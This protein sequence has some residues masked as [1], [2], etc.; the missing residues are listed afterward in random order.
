MRRLTVAGLPAMLAM[1]LTL[2]APACKRAKH[3]ESAPELLSVVRVDDP[4]A[5]AQLVGG[6]YS[7][8]GNTWRWTA[9]KFSVN[10]RPPSRGAQEGAR[11][12]LRLNIP[13]VVFR[14][15]GAVTLSATAGGSS[16]A[17]QKYTEAGDYVYARDV[18]AGALSG[19][20]VSIQFAT[21]KAIPAGKLEKRELG[22][23][24]SS[25]GLV[26]KP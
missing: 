20:S 25:I 26:S 3:T 15:M 17:P 23:I 5:E 24:V 4:R 1:G 6:F 8:E 22:L 19:D 14:Q 10:L 18:P 16:L 11:L 7:L 21:D 13:D 2:A 12:E 9:G